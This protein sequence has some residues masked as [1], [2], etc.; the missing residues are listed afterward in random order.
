[1]EYLIQ[2]F[3]NL[4]ANQEQARWLLALSLGGAATLF[5]LGIM[6]LVTNATDPIRRRLRMINNGDDSKSNEHQMAAIVEP[7]SAYVLP[8][9]EKEITKIRTHLIHA[10]FRS[11][12]AFA[13]FYVIK[14][15]LALSLMALALLGATLYPKLTLYQVVLVT[16][17][18]GFI[19]LI[20]PNFILNRKVERR[21]RI[22]MNSFP[23]ALDLLVASTEAGL[24]LNAALERVSEE[25]MVSSPSLAEELAL[26]NAQ[27]RA[28]VDRV[29]ALRNLSSRTGLK[30]IRGLVSLLTQ[31]LRFGT[32]VADTL[33]IY[34]E[35]FRDKRMQRA[36]EKAALI[37][38]KMIFP[39]VLC[40]FPA[41][42]V[43]AVGPAIL[44]ILEVLRGL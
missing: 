19:G 18:T 6:F 25:L 16:F 22:L 21:Q 1:M 9:K 26:V 38:T 14:T 40:M 32:S 37:G 35:E 27:I 8:K 29:E 23:D 34:A 12:N 39:L 10:G 41:F 24:G 2:F 7:I 44:G 17:I 15:L 3:N 11:Q 31:S 20:I 42:F 33:R 4:A 43:V 30:D 36:E 28:G 13:S 5:A